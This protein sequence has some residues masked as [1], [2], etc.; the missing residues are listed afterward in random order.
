[1]LALQVISLFQNIFQQVGL[2][3]Y[4]KPYR[5]VATSPGVSGHSHFT[6]LPSPTPSEYQTLIVGREDKRRRR[7]RRAGRKRGREEK[8]CFPSLPFFPAPSPS[9]VVSPLAPVSRPPHD[10]PPGLR[11]YFN[12]LESFFGAHILLCDYSAFPYLDAPISSTLRPFFVLTEFSW[13][14]QCGVIECVPDSKSR[15]QLGRQTE[16]DL[17]EYYQ[18][19]YGDETSAAFQQVRLQFAVAF[20]GHRGNTSS[21]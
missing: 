17:Y 8:G 4:L 3:V 15:D 14:L 1:M 6:S 11:G 2:N 21:T 5:V 7:G 19:T 18:K 13:R 12:N 9:A 16:V 10:L 20:R